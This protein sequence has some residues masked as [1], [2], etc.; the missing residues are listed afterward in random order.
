MLCSSGFNK[1]QFLTEFDT[2]LETMVGANQNLIKCGDFNIDQLS[3]TPMKKRFED[4][5]S[6]INLMDSGITI[7]TSTTKSSLDLFLT[8]INK[9]QCIV[10][11]ISYD[12]TDH[13]PEFFCLRKYDKNQDKS[14]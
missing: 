6:T 5:I 9:N 12:I 8:K 4:F 13:Y 3:L 14:I 7:E 1:S 11:S 10:I 2:Y